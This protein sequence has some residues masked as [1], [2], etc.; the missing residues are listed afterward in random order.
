MLLEVIEQTEPDFL[1]EN[2]I[3]LEFLNYV[4]NNLEYLFAC[5]EKNWLTIRDA[6]FLTENYSKEILLRVCEFLKTKDW[7]YLQLRGIKSVRQIFRFYCN[8]FE[9]NN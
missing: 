1:E 9:N 6:K 7:E 5:K 3:A 2:N 4:K 8:E